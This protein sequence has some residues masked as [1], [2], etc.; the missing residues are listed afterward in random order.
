MRIRRPQYRRGITRSGAASTSVKLSKSSLGAVAVLAAA[1]VTPVAAVGIG[2]VA[3]DSPAPSSAADTGVNEVS[4]D[5]APLAEGVTQD[6]AGGG[7]QVRE[8]SADTPFSM[9]GVTW[10]GEHDA[11]AR[12]RAQQPD[13]SWGEWFEADSVAGDLDAGQS[14]GG[15]GGTEPVYL[16]TE[17]TKVQIALE[18]VDL[19]ET[20]IGDS[21]EALTSA[22]ET[23]TPGAEEDIAEEQSDAANGESADSEAQPAGGAIADA[24]AG[25]MGPEGQNSD[26]SKPVVEDSGQVAPAADETSLDSPGVDAVLLSPDLN[27]PTPAPDMQ[28]GEYGDVANPKK[29]SIISRAGW[30]ADESM[31]CQSPSYDDSLAAGVVHHTAGS[32]NYSKAQSAGVVRGIYIYHAQNLGWCDVG[33]NVLVDK[34]GQAFEGRAGGLDKNVQ[35][36]HAGGFNGNTW[37]I[38]MMGDYSTITPPDATVN[39]V[40]EIL[41]WRLALAGV[42]PKGKDTH[43][44]EGTSYTKYPQGTK[45]TLPNIF[46]HRDVGLTTCPGDAGYAQMGKIRNIAAQYA[47]TGGG[48]GS[49]STKT[50]TTSNSDGDSGGSSPTT[51]RP[52]S[53]SEVPTDDSGSLESALGG[54]SSDLKNLDTKGAAELVGKLLMR[55]SE[56][57][58]DGLKALDLVETLG[59]IKTIGTALVQAGG[60]GRIGK[61]FAALGGADGVLGKALSGVQK[62]N[63]V[64]YAK[65]DGGAIYDSEATGAHAVLGRIGDAWAAQGFEHGPLGLPTEE[66]SDNGD[67][68]V[69]QQF[70]NGRIVYDLYS[71]TV[72]VEG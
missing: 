43:Y 3:D 37:G 51:G 41:G 39:K 6:I 40:G 46:A 20:S 61:L 18:G 2:Q 8:V 14:T 68:T 19:D 47:K 35:G 60:D 55:G 42:D 34:Y 29:P 10:K 72:K 71:G 17:T 63:D 67:G 7:E 30:G 64:S 11:T 31:R 52:T 25:L 53:E 23:S 28:M 21:P 22:P 70:E 66:E 48:S 5:S 45:V 13:G 4:L 15:K 62:Y 27:S 57:N 59:S 9:V 50:T 49:S 1:A 33:Y 58:L 36:A 16:G 12:I 56:L 44:S 32:N 54:G 24:L 38:S 65:F 69:S 26:V